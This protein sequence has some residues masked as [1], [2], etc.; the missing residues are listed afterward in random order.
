MNSGIK[1]FLISFFLFHLYFKLK[2][3]SLK[4]DYLPIKSSGF[5]P[6]DFT[7]STKKK[8]EEDVKQLEE[9]EN[10]VKDNHT[11]Y[12]ILTNYEIDKQLHGGNI[13]LND[14]ITIYV[15]KVVDELLKDDLELRKQLKIFVTKIPETN[16]FCMGKGYIFVDIG[17]ITQAANEAQL[18]YVLSHEIAHFVKNHNLKTYIEFKKI[19]KEKYKKK[20]FQDRDIKMFTFSKANET[21]ADIV[22]Y[23]MFKKSSYDLN[24]INTVFDVLQ[25]SYLPFDEIKFDSTFFNDGDYIIAGKYFLKKTQEIKKKEDYDDTRSTHPNIKKR[26]ESIDSLLGKIPKVTGKKFIVSEEIFYKV[27]D[28]CRF[29]IC[30]IFLVE[31]NYLDAINSAYILQK[32]FPDNLYLQKIIMKSLY[33]MTLY[34]NGELKFDNESYRKGPIPDYTKTEG[35]SQRLN[36]FLDKLPQQ[37]I[38]ILTL[39]YIWNCHKK[40]PKETIFK[41]YS[42]SL[43]TMLP[44]KF[45][46]GINDFYTKTKEEV[47]KAENIKISSEH[48]YKFAF[49]KF[50]SNDLE[51]RTKF[52]EVSALA[53]SNKPSIVGFKVYA[54]QTGKPKKENA[55]KIETGT[56]NKVNIN[57]IV[58]VDPFYQKYDET[59]QQTSLYIISDDKE[60]EFIST[61]KTGA[62]KNKLSYEIIDPCTFTNSD[63]QKYNDYSLLQDWYNERMDGGENQ[64]PP[65]F[66]SDEIDNLIK[67][68]NT[69][70]FLWTGV[71]STHYKNEAGIVN[72]FKYIVGTYYYAIVFDIETGKVIKKDFKIVD[73][74]DTHGRISDFVN[75]TLKELSEK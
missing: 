75:T 9:K 4:D 34:K 13:L 37:E 50:L 74:S 72:A 44:N 53:T 49:V 51:F 3:Q 56:L 38:A 18:A 10:T 33:A 41:K 15:N 14:E 32:K 26:K 63:I 68:Y 71:S 24:S 47:E 73:K 19:E 59:R 40:F 70:Y 69:K 62:T 61:L 54:P 55:K 20:T 16:A 65:I 7:Y 5:I 17:L 64:N 66:N 29:E 48:Y 52:T 67:H 60:S 45:H 11:S 23:E 30:R 21:E 12:T 35:Y 57:K 2:S 31:R 58:I 6:D 46:L 42:D 43:F 27:R 28:I 36:F 1:L 22:G 8:V 39:N 25:Y